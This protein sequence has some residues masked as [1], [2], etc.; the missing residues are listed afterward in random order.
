MP[1]LPPPPPPSHIE[2]FISLDERLDA[3]A[4]RVPV[5]NA[6]GRSV[7]ASLAHVPSHV[8]INV[9]FGPNHRDEPCLELAFD[10][11][12][13][14]EPVKAGWVE[15]QHGAYVVE[16]EVGEATGRIH[17]LR[18]KVPDLS[19]ASV[20]AMR[21]GIRGLAQDYVSKNEASLRQQATLNAIARLLYRLLPGLAS[22]IRRTIGDGPAQEPRG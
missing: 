4:A 13:E 12:S 10:Y 16:M 14:T 18:M 8:R 19:E 15:L 7:S 11:L 22:D 3:A 20:D 21:A 6:P 9:R 1:A 2:R 5:P 17:H